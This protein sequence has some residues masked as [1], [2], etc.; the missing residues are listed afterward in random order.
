VLE[1]GAEATVEET[2]TEE[3]TAARLGS[4]DVPVLGT[5]AVLALVE[6]AAVAIVADSLE[7]DQTTVGTSV[8]LEHLAPTPVGAQVTASAGV[9]E[10]D[11][12]TIRFTFEVTDAQ[13]PI[14]RGTHTR[15]IVNRD[16]FLT[17]ARE[18]GG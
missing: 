4:G 13:G 14:A 11:G 16:R 18:R 8:E 10:V 7:T 9:I 3:M 6:A 17:T 12:R 15:V 1:P 5:P 2:V